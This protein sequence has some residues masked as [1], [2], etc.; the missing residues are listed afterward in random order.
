MFI[1]GFLVPEMKSYTLQKREKYYHLTPLSRCKFT[2]KLKKLLPCIGSFRNPGRGPLMCL[3][4][5]IVWQNLWKQHIIF[6]KEFS[7][8]YIGF[9]PHRTCIYCH[10]WTWT[11][12]ENSC[13]CKFASSLKIFDILIFFFKQ[14]Q[15]LVHQGRFS[16]HSTSWLSA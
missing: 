11:Q 4:E 3:Q 6:L 5:Y 8:K 10:H 15:W 14:I 9:R 16:V 12:R 2:V 1:V 13:I 7:S